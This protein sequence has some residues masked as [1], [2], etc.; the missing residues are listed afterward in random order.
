M[1]DSYTYIRLGS[2]GRLKLSFLSGCAALLGVF[3]YKFCETVNLTRSVADVQE[4]SK[5]FYVRLLF[6][7]TRSRLTG[8]L[9]NQYVP[10]SLRPYL[11]R[12]VGAYV[13][14]GI[15]FDEVR[16]PLDSY[17]CVGHLFARTLKHGARQLADVSKDSLV[18]PVDGKVICVENVTRQRIQQVKGTSFNVNAFVGSNPIA[19]A[20]KPLRY[21]VLYLSPRHYHHFHSPCDFKISRRN[22]FSGETLPVFSGFLSRFNDT[23]TVNERVVYSGSWEHGALYFAAVAA[24]NVGNIRLA[25]EPDLRTNEW[26][27]QL[28][29]LGGD[30][31]TKWH[32]SENEGLHVQS[33]EH[34][35]EFRLG[36]TVVLLFE[37]PE[38]YQWDVKEG[39]SVKVGDRLGGI[40]P[41]ALPSKP[42]YI[43]YTCNTDMLYCASVSG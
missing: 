18:S 42:R 11:Y 20:Q 12:L 15:A 14:G 21:V 24:Y 8:I 19:T 40:G 10:P 17:K 39:D 7:R 16:Y 23:F 43:G 33:G 4:P 34:L 26:R 29:Y 38:D 28:H 1:C 3:N 5:L 6:G 2:E 37:S 22:H 9:M 25:H 41:P 31:N 13:W 35:G 27:T 30:I 32:Q 36:S